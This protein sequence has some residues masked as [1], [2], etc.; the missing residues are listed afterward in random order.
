MIISKGDHIHLKTLIINLLMVATLL[1]KWLQ[2][3]TLVLVGSRGLIACRD[4][5]RVEVMITT[6]GK[7]VS[8]PHIR[9]QFLG[10]DLARHLL[11]LWG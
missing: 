1:I 2:E 4:L 8:L 10:M 6:A 9:L 5:H 7:E 11:Q 3:A